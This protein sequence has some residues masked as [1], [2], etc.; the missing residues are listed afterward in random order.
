LHVIAVGQIRGASAALYGV[1]T[2]RLNQ[3]VRRNRQR[4]P[5]DFLFELTQDEYHALKLQFATSKAGRGG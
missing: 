1:N 3:Q 4:F 5:A 2:A